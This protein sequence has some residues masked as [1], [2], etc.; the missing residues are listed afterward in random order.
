M[1][2]RVSGFLDREGLST[3]AAPTTLDLDVLA[4]PKEGMLQDLEED[5]S[6]GTVGL[7]G[8]CLDSSAWKRS[9]GFTSLERAPVIAGAAARTP[10][11]AVSR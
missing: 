1:V 10:G 2:R 8:H 9:S 6:L 5:C 3:P 4:M 7:S 11:A